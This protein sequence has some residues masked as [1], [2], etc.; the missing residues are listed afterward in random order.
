MAGIVG[1]HGAALPAL[2]FRHFTLPIG[3]QRRFS[4][5][6]AIQKAPL[7]TPRI[8]HCNGGLGAWRQAASARGARPRNEA[9]AFGS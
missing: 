2:D 8:A 1:G 6:L 3:L 9:A 5:C 7:A 4:E